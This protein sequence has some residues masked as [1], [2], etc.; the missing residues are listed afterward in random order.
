MDAEL[1]AVVATALGG[2]YREDTVVVRHSSSSRR[3]VG[4][5]G[6]KEVGSLPRRNA[7]A[8]L[9]HHFG[10]SSLIGQR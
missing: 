4:S 1:A 10:S 8:D 7:H 2:G 9:Q 3:R 6:L 5:R